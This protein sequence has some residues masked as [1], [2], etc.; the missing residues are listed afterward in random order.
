MEATMADYDVIIIGTRVAGAATALLFARR[1]LWVLAVD[2]TAFPSDTLS[3]HQIQVSGAARLH[4]WGLLD[5]LA[6]AGTPATRR[7]RF[8]AGGV[9]L[10]GAYP[11]YDGADALYSPR[12]TVLDALLVDAARVAGADVHERF[13]VDELL[14]SGGRVSGIRGTTRGANG[15]PISHTA[16]LVVG[17]DG[18]RSLV[19]R[20]VG[21]AAYRRQPART[22]AVYGYWC[23]LANPSAGPADGELYQRPGL[24][25]PVF[26]TNDGLTMVAV[27][28]PLDRLTEFRR[29]PQ[30]LVLAALDACADLGERARDAALVEHLRFAP[31]LPHEFRVPYGPGWALVGDAGLVL[32]PISALG[33]SHAFRDAELLTDAVTAALAAGRPIESEL[34][35]YHRRRDEQSRSMFAFTARL[36]A[37]VAHRRSPRWGQRLLLRSIVDRPREITR[38]LGVLAGV[39]PV[40]RYLSAVNVARL[41]AA[42]GHR[43]RDL[44]PMPSS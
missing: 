44:V 6:A 19:A 33:I 32:N 31:D 24:A 12:R 17:A 2:R 25:V 26:P 9:V 5:R 15:R 29:D 27:L 4:R 28:A 11:K 16:R 35:A 34:P 42:R 37:D 38:F 20:A 43:A 36:A 7:V 41:L 14:W 22:F 3:T 21:A 8:D 18:K 13:T 1:G 39:E 40:D 10:D 30:R 23:G